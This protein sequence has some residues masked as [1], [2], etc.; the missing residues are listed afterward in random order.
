MFSL[1]GKT[2]LITGASSGIGRAIAI[3]MAHQ[4]AEVILSGTRPDAL[5]ETAAQING[6]SHIITA[7]L[8][9][10]QACDDLLTQAYQQCADIDILVNNGGITRD[11]LAMRM[12]DD[13]WDM[14][15]EVNL[16]SA[17]RLARGMVKNMMKKRYGRIINMASIVALSGNAGQANYTAAKAGMIA[18]SKSLALEVA[19][20]GITVN[21]IAPGFIE[22]AIT[23]KIPEKNREALLANIPQ[24]RM[25]QADD[26]AAAAIYLASDEA[27][28]VTGETINVNGGLFMSS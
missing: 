19:N 3:K 21:C 8:S 14:V 18:M 28:Y 25:G 5:E 16:T 27:S 26:I 6:T 12:K 17:F 23:E 1:T 4:G 2:A 7:D 13:D 15:L 22:T 11:A 20:R 10:R 24:A 9:Q